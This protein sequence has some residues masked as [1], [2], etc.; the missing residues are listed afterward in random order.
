MGISNSAQLQ[1][2][3]NRRLEKALTLTME[4]LMDKLHEFIEQEVYSNKPDWY[5]RSMELLN[6][7]E[8]TKPQL[9]ANGVE[10]VLSFSQ[11]ISHSGEPN[12]QH[13]MS[14][15]DN[16]SL[17]EIV[18]EGKIGNICNFP[19]LGERPFWNKF[20]EWTNANIYI[21]FTKHANSV[22]LKGAFVSHTFS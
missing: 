19:Q 5:N 10:S 21:I 6:N 9:V 16:N 4:E 15:V 22:G 8:Y 1:V 13:G 18:N 14:F 3:V 2:E 12:W 17:V 20:M 7:W 11:P